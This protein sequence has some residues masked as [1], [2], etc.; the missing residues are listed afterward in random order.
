MKLGE[1]KAK[2]LGGP[3]TLRFV[4]GEFQEL[5]EALGERD[6]RHVHEEW[7]DVTLCSQAWLAEYLPLDWT[8]ILPG[9]GL[10]SAHKFAARTSVWEEIFDHHNVDFRMGCL[11]KGSNYRKAHKVTWALGQAGVLEVDFDWVEN[12]V[13]GFEES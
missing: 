2:F 9:L 11:K 4:F 3:M 10:F 1:Y 7:N 8:P 12:L 13:G 5:V 6:W